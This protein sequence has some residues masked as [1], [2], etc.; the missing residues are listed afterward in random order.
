MC[1]AKANKHYFK[2]VFDRNQWCTSHRKLKYVRLA[3]DKETGELRRRTGTGSKNDLLFEGFYNT[4]LMRG[5]VGPPN[6]GNM[7]ECRALTV[8]EK[9]FGRRFRQQQGTEITRTG[10]TNA[11]YL[12]AESFEEGEPM[13]LG[14]T[15]TPKCSSGY[16]PKP[17]RIVCSAKSGGGGTC[18]VSQLQFEREHLSHLNT[19]PACC[20]KTH[21]QFTLS[22]T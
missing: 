12:C 13:Q 7:F 19:H 11:K 20:Q 17:N 3:C 14:A 15:C 1:P 22:S 10:C 6:Q 2:R 21:T 4:E 8:A 5:T 9:M 18:Y 16:I